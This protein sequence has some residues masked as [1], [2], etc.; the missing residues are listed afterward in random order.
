MRHSPLNAALNYRGNF[1]GRNG[2]L[3]NVWGTWIFCFDIEFGDLK[4]F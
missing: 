1:S 4:Q 3:G 2:F